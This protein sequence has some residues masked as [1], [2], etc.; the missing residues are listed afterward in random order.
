MNPIWIIA[1]VAI[2]VVLIAWVAGVL[3]VDA[4]RKNRGRDD[5]RPPPLPD[6]RDVVNGGVI[7]GDRGQTNTPPGE[8]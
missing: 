4:R 5:G 1:L 6:G 3:V 7:R 8:G 2:V